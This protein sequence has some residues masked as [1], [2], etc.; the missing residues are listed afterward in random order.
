MRKL[1]ITAMV[2][3]LV[4]GLGVP[5][6]ADLLDGLWSY[7]DFED[8]NDLGK[9]KMG[10]HHGTWMGTVPGDGKQVA[11]VLGQAMNFEV[12]RLYGGHYR[13]GVGLQRVLHQ[14]GP[15]CGLRQRRRRGQ[16]SPCAPWHQ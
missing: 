5:A 10:V 8:P 2:I 16:H 13:L 12:C 14:L 4:L 3:G 1:A 11:G 6:Q 9:D 7:Y 15:Y